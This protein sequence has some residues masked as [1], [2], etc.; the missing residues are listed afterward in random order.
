FDSLKDNPAIDVVYVVLPNSMHAEYT[1]RA[2]KAGKHVLCEKP[3]A[4]SVEECQAMIEACKR[5]QKKLMVGYRMRYEPMTN[6]AIELAQSPQA[7]GVIKHIRAEAGFSIGDPTQ[8]RLKKAMAG[9]GP[10]MDMGVYAINAVR[11]LSGK[12]PVEVAA[13][14]YATPNDPRFTEV[15]ETV[16]FEL[17]FKEGFVGSCLTSYGVNSKRFRVYGTAGQLESEPFQSYRG[18]HL[19]QL[20]KSNKRIEIAYEPVNHFATEMDHLGRCILGDTQPLT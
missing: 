2:A 11:Y 16:T 19:W 4:N 7:T 13:A 14:T 18:N 20:D 8:W 10:L 9:G 3:M 6:R 5:A 12:E 1:I 15:E 17:R